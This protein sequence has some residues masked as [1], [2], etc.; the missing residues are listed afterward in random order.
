[1]SSNTR[2][3]NNS[4]ELPGTVAGTFFPGRPPG[5]FPSEGH[6]HILAHGGHR[7]SL[8]MDSDSR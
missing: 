4:P 2:F 8:M 6:M 5:P 1:M 7:F 3:D